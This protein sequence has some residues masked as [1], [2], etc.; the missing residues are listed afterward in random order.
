MGCNKDEVTNAS[1]DSSLSAAYFSGGNTTIFNN[2]STAYEQPS[3]NLNPQE[4]LLHTEGDAAFEATFVTAPATNNSGLGPLFN[5]NACVSCH[6]RN[7]RSAAPSNSDLKGFLLRLSNGAV[8]AHGAPAPV[9]GFGGQLQTKAIFGLQPEGQVSIQYTYQVNN[10]LDGTNYELQIPSYQ[11]TQTYTQLPPGTH[12]SPR[13][14]PAIFGLGL[15]E[16]VSESEIL[17]AADPND[18]N[19][20]GISGK[21]N[22]VWNYIAQQMQIG[23][24]GWKA[25]EPTLYQ[26]TAEAYLGDMGITSPNFTTENST[27]QP[28]IDSLQDDPEITDDIV[29]A[30]TFYAQSLGVPAR[31]NM[32]DPLVK[33]G[34]LLFN[35]AKCA[36]CHRSQMNTAQLAGVPS[37]SNQIIY[38]YTDLLLHDMGPD[39]ADGFAA[40]SANGSE[41]RTPPLWGI[42]LV[43][44]VNGHSYFLHDGRARNLSEAILWHGGEAAASKQFFVN[45]SATERLAIIRFLES[46]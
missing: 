37:V 12:I 26:Q 36:T 1:Q 11:I 17:A 2:G 25:T 39:L 23:R 35:A 4:F 32:N 21:P 29:K 30:A 40:F 6:P 42:G 41:W 10:F 7:G 13:V 33:Q 19:G 34:A 45:L 8:A 31:R 24:F 15:L 43:P 27:G 14:G 18:A 3:A 16:A 22:Y 5:Q 9:A 46:L 44:V 28:Q 38:P 20:D